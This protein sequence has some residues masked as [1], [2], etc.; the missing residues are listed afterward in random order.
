MIAV[1]R[2]RRSVSSVD[3]NERSTWTDTDLNDA[4]IYGLCYCGRPRRAQFGVDEEGTYAL[5]HSCDEGHAA[6]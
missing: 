3:A 6:D 5:W 4:A 1:P 2:S